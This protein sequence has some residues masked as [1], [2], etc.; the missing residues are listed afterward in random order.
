MQEFSFTLI[1]R[2]LAFPLFDDE[3][4]TRVADLFNTLILALVGLWLGL[5]AAQI[6][7]HVQNPRNVTVSFVVCALLLA[8][9]EIARRGHVPVATFLFCSITLVGLS[10]VAY[11]NGTVR[12][13]G[14]AAMMVCVIVPTM[15]IGRRMGFAFVGLTSAFVFGLSRAELAGMLPPQMTASLDPTNQWLI[16]TVVILF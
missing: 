16:F 8:I 14:T 11:N 3:D 13:M 10:G 15:L 12:A 7:L 4:K 2:W 5:T 6:A 9:R 1:R